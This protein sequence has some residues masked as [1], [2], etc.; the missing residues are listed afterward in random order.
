MFENVAAV[1]TLIVSLVVLLLVLRVIVPLARP[2]I[3]LPAT[4]ENM[5]EMLR[6]T[7]Q[8]EARRQDDRVRKQIERTPPDMDGQK[9][10][11]RAGV[12]VGRQ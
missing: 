1:A 3:D 11:V 4:L 8:Q 9:T 2:Q 10:V 5:A 12:P 7:I 6:D